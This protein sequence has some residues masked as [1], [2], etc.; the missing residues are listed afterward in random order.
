MNLLDTLALFI[1]VIFL[2]LSAQCGASWNYGMSPL[3]TMGES[4]IQ[5]L[6]LHIP[7]G[8]TIA[9]VGSTG[10]GKYISETVVEAVR[11]AG[12]HHS[13]WH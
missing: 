9:I 2:C 5:N 11:Q 12:T 4:V 7:A 1:Q 3:P 13:R 10:S 6:S 8:K